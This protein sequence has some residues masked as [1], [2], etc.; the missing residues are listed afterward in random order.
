MIFQKI[1]NWGKM[2]IFFNTRVQA[3]GFQNTDRAPIAQNNSSAVSGDVLL[4]GSQLLWTATKATAAFL[5]AYKPR[6]IF[7]SEYEAQEKCFLNNLGAANPVELMLHRNDLEIKRIRSLTKEFFS[8]M[9]SFSVF[10]T[11][12][13]QVTE[14]TG[15]P[16]AGDVA[17][18]L[19]GYV[20]CDII[21]AVS[22]ILF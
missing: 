19:A 4:F 13:H 22:K 20:V 11:F 2:S 3:S 5:M 21:N 14:S 18:L 8:H 7:L 12:K 15:I 16:D 10:L 17:G 6:Q 1:F 9:V